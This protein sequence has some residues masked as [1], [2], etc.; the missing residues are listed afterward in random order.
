MDREDDVG[1]YIVYLVNES[2]LFDLDRMDEALTTDNE[3][4]HFW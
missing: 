3:S 1:P 2:G 4:V